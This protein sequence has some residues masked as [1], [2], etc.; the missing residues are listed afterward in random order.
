MSSRQG[1]RTDAEQH[2]Q[3]SLH[4]SDADKKKLIQFEE[5]NK[6]LKSKCKEQDDQLRRLAVQIQSVEQK[7]QLEMRQHRAATNPTDT[8]LHQHQEFRIETEILEKERH[9]EA[10][11]RE[12]LILLH[13]PQ[14]SGRKSPS[15][16]KHAWIATSDKPKSHKTHRVVGGRHMTSS[17]KEDELRKETQVLAAAFEIAKQR[18]QDERSAAEK[19]Y[20]ASVDRISGSTYENSSNLK[21]RISEMNFAMRTLEDRTEQTAHALHVVRDHDYNL[22]VDVEALKSQL[23][24]QKEEVSSLLRQKQVNDLAFNC[25]HDYFQIDIRVCSFSMGAAQRPRQKRS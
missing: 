21:H 13:A 7:L 17:R 25:F 22:N 23:H 4:I 10:L 20:T 15:L 8:G 6:V 18:L 24:G 9:N 5:Q 12:I 2:E 19:G 3:Y 1:K 14:F 16:T 11:K